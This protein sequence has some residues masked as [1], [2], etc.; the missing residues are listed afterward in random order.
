VLPSSRDDARALALIARYGR[1]ATAFQALGRGLS[2]WFPPRADLQRDDTG[3]VAFAMV[4]GGVVAVGEP[5]AAPDE[6]MAVAEAFVASARAAKRRVSFFATEGNLAA[7]PHFGRLLLGEQPV[8]NPQHWRAQL[9]G[10]RSLREQVRRARAKGVRVVPLADATHHVQGAVDA[11]LHRWV[12][13]RS[14]AAMQFVVDVDP[15]GHASTRRLFAAMQ[16]TRMVAL[17]SMAPVPARNGWLFEHL[18]RDPE[19]PNGT[20]ELLVD[21]GMQALAADEVTWATLGLAPLKGPIRGWLRVVRALSRPLF[22][23]AGLAAFKRK[24]G[25]ERWEPIYL[26]YPQAQGSVWSVID[27]LRAFAGGSLLL[28]GW[29]TVRRGSPA[30]LRA[31]E[32]LLIPWTIALALAPA[33]VPWFPHTGVHTA[34][35]LFDVGLVIALRALRQTPATAPRAPRL[36]TGLAVAVTVDAVCTAAQAVLWTVPHLPANRGTAGLVVVLVA[37]AGPLLAARVLWGLQRRLR[38][39]RSA[40]AR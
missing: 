10:H 20:A 9:Q 25:P 27:V 28:F 21:A 8:W 6:A 3:L 34:W 5:T 37:C 38:S 15:L 31:L 22:N 11:L 29:R 26:V 2:H 33:A 14:M 18:L 32:W 16:G 35:V 36:A 19:A 30:V 23:F 12:A 13:T 1:T 39:L 7:S 24:L 17:L 40:P 4:P